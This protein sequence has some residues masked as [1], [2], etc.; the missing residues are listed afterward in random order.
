MFCCA[1]SVCSLKCK[2]HEERVNFFPT[3]ASPVM[4][5]CLEH[6]LNEWIYNSGEEYKIGVSLQILALSL[7]ACNLGQVT[8]FVN[9]SFLIYKIE[10]GWNKKI[11]RKCFLAQCLGSSKHW[12]N[13]GHI[14]SLTLVC[15]RGTGNL[16]PRSTGGLLFPWAHS[17]LWQLQQ[18]E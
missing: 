4:E 15:S 12:T 10:I 17:W 6:L 2:L 7:T 9:L 14:F 11:Y 1:F 18:L 5:H 13:A 8:T 3:S 16:F